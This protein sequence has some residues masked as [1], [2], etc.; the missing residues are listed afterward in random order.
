MR[1][2]LIEDDQTVASAVEEALVLSHYAVDCVADGDAADEAVAVND[3]DAILLD[4]GI[5]G[6]SGI[7]LLRSWREQEMATPVLMLTGRAEIEDRVDGL[8][9]G[10]DDYLTKPFS[11]AE[12]LARVGSLI[13]RR[14]RALQM[15]LVAADVAMDRAARRVSMAGDEIELSPKEFALLEYLLHRVGEVVTRTE[16]SEHVWDNS[17]DAMSNVIDVTVHRLRRKIDGDRPETLLHTVTGVGYV[18]KAE[19]QAK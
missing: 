14:E 17:F 15:R 2:L 7:E 18:L 10:A 8:N 9:S 12:L 3:Y 5:P 6:R 19:R 16:I 4:W 11:L 1:I 13:R